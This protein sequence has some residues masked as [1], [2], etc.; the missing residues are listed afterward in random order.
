MIN[1]LHFYWD[2]IVN[3]G[4]HN[5]MNE[6]EHVQLKILNLQAIY[7]I[8]ACSML[9]IK[10]V[11]QTYQDTVEI[12]II[13]LFISVI[14]V[15]NY[16]KELFY[17]KVYWTALFPLII[18]GLVVMYG[19]EP[20]GEMFFIISIVNIFILFEKKYI[21]FLLTLLVCTLCSVALLY[22]SLYE[23]A[24]AAS[25]DSSD[26]FSSFLITVSCIAV[27]I[28]IYTKTLRRQL[29][30]SETNNQALQDANADLEHFTY[31]ASHNLKTPLRNILGSIFFMQRKVS[32]TEKELL[33]THI[34]DIKTSA[35]DMHTLIND[36]MEYAVFI[37]N[38]MTNT[39]VVNLHEL[40]QNITK[41][42]N[43]SLDKEAI[44]RYNGEEKINSNLTLV[45]AI[46]QNLIEN[47]IKYN[48]SEIPIIE[49]EVIKEKN[50]FLVKVTDNGIGINTEYHD[51]IFVMF[52][53]LHH[54][55]EYEGTG[56]GL[57]MCKRL[58]NK[59]NGEV[60]LKSEI[61][62]GSTFFVRIPI[63]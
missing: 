62:K 2:N 1:K 46:L 63:V 17:A 29:R 3:I 41:S 37:Q 53:R 40:A 34:K 39:A 60:W 15:L 38:E 45:K 22:N 4:H 9:L 19:N 24:L 43:I 49:V 6:E 23:S 54:N 7:S 14:L 10:S 30:I 21:Q 31:M 32:E 5:R 28:N 56:I 13:I 18:F 16:L 42:V 36:I 8:I 20:H 27:T 58:L 48:H 51:K 12:L 11:F 33:G 52:K 35:N 59:Y 47:G 55:T 25:T 26:S 57:A 44:F 61:G 50:S